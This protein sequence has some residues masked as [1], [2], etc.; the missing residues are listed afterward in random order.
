MRRKIFSFSGVLGIAPKKKGKTEPRPISLIPTDGRIVQRAILNVLQKQSKLQKYLQV[1]TSFGGIEKRGGVPQA[2]EKA[3]E[4]IAKGASYYIKSDISKFFTKIP[5]KEVLNILR[6]EL[7]D[8][9]FIELLD[10]SI[11][12][13]VKVLSGYEKYIHFFDFE[14]FGTPQGCSLSPLIGNILLFEFDNKMNDS[15]VS[16][17]RYMDDFIVLATSERAAN[18]AFKKA[19]SLLVKYGLSAYESGPKVAKAKADKGWTASRFE[20]LGVE[21]DGSLRRPSRSN[22][23]RLLDRIKENIK[24]SQDVIAET[25]SKEFK[26]FKDLYEKSYSKP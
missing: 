9:E 2:I 22:R 23:N 19:Q 7:C 12:L 6:R 13:E 24:V 8:D 20:Y 15:N 3:L 1:E 14:E 11:R 4:L 26:K 5:V 25:K 18:A 16:C 17:L 21:F 10:T